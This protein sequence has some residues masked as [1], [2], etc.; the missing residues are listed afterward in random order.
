MTLH[1]QEGPDLADGQVLSVAKRDQLIK[2]AEKL[3]C[4]SKNFSLVQSPAGARHH[5]SEQ[6]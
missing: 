5:L 4:I 1:L 3:V 2:C 6:V